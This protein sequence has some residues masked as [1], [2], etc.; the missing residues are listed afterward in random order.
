[1]GAYYTQLPIKIYK[2]IVENSG[3]KLNRGVFFAKQL[4]ELVGHP[5]YSPDYL[6][7]KLK[8]H[9]K[10]NRFLTNDKVIRVVEE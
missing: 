10:G 8:K 4:V 5:P 3:R 2:K 9:L 1:M 7:P 6:F